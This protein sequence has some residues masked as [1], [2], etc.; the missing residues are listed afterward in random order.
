MSTDVVEEYVE[1][2]EEDEADRLYN[3]GYDDGY[4]SRAKRDLDGHYLDGW[5]AG[6]ADAEDSDD[7]EGYYDYDYDYDEDD[8]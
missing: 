6:D 2:P 8:D 1:S 4:N 5:Y 3:A 7:Y